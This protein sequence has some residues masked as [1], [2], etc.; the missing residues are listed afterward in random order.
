[1]DQNRLNDYLKVIELN[2]AVEKMY[3]RLAALDYQGLK[4]NDE[5]NTLV[6]LIKDTATNSNKIFKKYPLHDNDILNF[7]N[8]IT[9]I[10]KYSTLP[11]ITLL[12]DQAS[13]KIKRFLEHHFI[14]ELE[15]K[16]LTQ[17]EVIPEYNNILV[18][19]NGV[20][21]SLNNL[22]SLFDECGY[23]TLANKLEKDKKNLY[24][25]KYREI[26]QN[27]EITINKINL[28]NFTL[29]DYF[30]NEINKTTDKRIKKR[31]IKSKYILFSMFKSL[32][33]SFL[34][35]QTNY[36]KT[37]Y[38]QN[39]YKKLFN[40]NNNL[41]KYYNDYYIE[42]INSLIL[43]TLERNKDKY[44]NLDDRY[45][46]IILS[47]YLKTL[48]SLLNNKKDIDA[49]Y[50]DQDYII[51]ENHNNFNA[52]FLNTTRNLNEELILSRKL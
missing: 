23:T 11:L 14:Y 6:D 16:N 27:K 31:L 52:Q 38:Y 17:D 28:Q 37:K 33:D 48:I 21:Y 5:Y 3:K 45:K 15:N 41:N 25:K 47:I 44:N 29:L 42:Q 51:S 1:M 22:M 13:I 9:E 30:D 50:K 24:L 2:K 8:L 7:I 36:S 18:N 10:N 39:E 43:Y 32:E 35:D 40:K 12:N 4:N 26:I 46:D 20:K 19:F 49:I 34:E